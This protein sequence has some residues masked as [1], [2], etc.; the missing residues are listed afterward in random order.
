M[1]KA[2]LLIYNDQV[3]TRDDLKEVL[4]HNQA[5]YHWRYDLPNTFYL[6][7]EQSAANLYKLIQR[8]NQKR[9]R[10]LI[11]EV[12]QDK[13]GWLPK[14]TWTLLNKKGPEKTTFMPKAN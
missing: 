2:Y 5:I 8:F 10:F 3:G 7:S 11:G 9:G 1:K 6:I 12:G 14:K 4:D 13:Q